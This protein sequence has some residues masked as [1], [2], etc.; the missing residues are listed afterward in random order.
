VNDNQPAPLTRG[1]IIPARSAYGT[2]PAS[3]WALWEAKGRAPHNLEGNGFT[4]RYAE[5]FALFAEHGITDVRLGIDWSR[6][7]PVAGKPDGAAL[8]QL[9]RVVE[10]A[11]SAGVNV[12]A[13]LIR[14]SVPGWF[15]DEGSF[16]DDRARGTRW[17]RFVNLVAEQIGDQVSGWFPLHDPTGFAGGAYRRG[18]RPPGVRDPEMGAKVL[19]GLW[20]AWRD[21]W[22]VLRG[23]PPVVTSLW[24]P[25]G[26]NDGT[27]RAREAERTMMDR[28]WNIAVGALRDGELAVPG[29]A[30]EEVPDLQDSCDIVGV[31]W[32]GGVFIDE[33]GDR[34][35]YPSD[36]RIDDHGRAPWAEG[37]DD[38]LHRLADQLPGRSFGIAEF[39][40]AS[41]DQGWVAEETAALF[42]AIAS[43]KADRIDVRH[44]FFSTVI[45]GFDPRRG[46]ILATGAFDRDRN[47]RPV[48]DLLRTR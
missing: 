19:R 7:E 2:A 42:D 43:A 10:S 16:A 26:Q 28:T 12:W 23:G 8:E 11:R 35:P 45:D 13:E 44:A 32:R 21:A 31:A 1:V 4:T 33:S 46:D 38:L 20:W 39:G 47:P 17:P 29:L 36:R 3:D 25:I 14:D 5:D 24:L 37:L 6:L 9:S 22:R 18:T 15:V 40:I 30:V 48:I 27:I 41:T 34:K